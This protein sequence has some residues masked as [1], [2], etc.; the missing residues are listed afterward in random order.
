M[1][2]KNH[3]AKITIDPFLGQV[4][5]S[6]KLIKL[7]NKEYHL[8]TYF[9]SNPNKVVTR[10]EIIN[11]VWGAEYDGNPR[12]ID[13]YIKMIRMKIDKDRSIIKTVSKV[14]Y[15]FEKGRDLEVKI[16]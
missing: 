8:L 15:K 9:I 5:L 12:V 10:S 16:L 13:T 11:H 7:T 6:D 1:S 14:G 2:E 4:Q 3:T